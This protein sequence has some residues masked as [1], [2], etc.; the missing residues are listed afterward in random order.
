MLARSFLEHHPES[1]FSALVLDDPERD[2]GPGEPFAVVR[3]DE[4]GIDRTLFGRIAFL[5]PVDRLALGVLPWFLDHLLAREGGELAYLAPPSWVLAPLDELVERRVATPFVAAPLGP[6]DAT[7]RSDAAQE[8]VVRVLGVFDPGFLIASAS[9]RESLDWWRAIVTSHVVPAV[10]FR[11]LERLLAVGRVD[12]VADPAAIVSL[13]GSWAAWLEPLGSGFTLHGRP[14]RA[15]RFLRP[16]FGPD[17]VSPESLREYAGR[18]NGSAGLAALCDAYARR[19]EEEGYEAASRLDDPFGTLPAGVRID[20]RMR[21]LY[22]YALYEAQAGADPPPEPFDSD[23][24]EAFLEWLNQATGE[25]G[26]SRYLGRLLA[27]RRDLRD[28]FPRIPGEDSARFL[29]LVRSGRLGERID[30]RL[31]PSNGVALDVAPAPEPRAAPP[32]RD[33]APGLNVIGPF[34]CAHG[35]GEASRQILAAIRETGIGTATALSN[36]GIS[37]QDLEFPVDGLASCRYDTNLLC[38]NVNE[39]VAF[40]GASPPELFEGRYTI[41]FWW[42]EVSTLPSDLL[43]AFELVDEVW[44]GSEF[45]RDALAA[46]TEKPVVV[47]PFAPQFPVVAPRP[48]EE[49]GLPEGFLFLFAFDVLSSLERKN[50]LAIVRAYREAFGPDD[51]AALLIKSVNGDRALTALEQLRYEARGRPDI[52]IVDGYMPASVKDEWIASCDCYVSLHR[53]EGFGLT[54]AEAMAFGKPVIAT[55]YSGNMTFMREDNSYLVPFELTTVPGEDALYPAGAVWADPDVGHAAM[56]MR[57][58]FERRAEAEAVGARAADH[59]RSVLSV[60]RSSAAIER[61]LQAIRE[62]RGGTA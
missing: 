15:F 22:W 17:W 55:A 19:L 50:P 4:I 7:E 2:V 11:P 46:Y 26:L 13:V 44:V 34:D 62:G 40:A 21:W 23:R 20:D 28:A 10:A 18:L 48:R 47:I 24:P 14:V 33:L 56:L 57:R 36:V 58:V 60:A 42:W 12:I 49:L 27:E 30:P 32:T 61:R 6:R 3:P 39:I 25:G 1:A 35:L 38:V 16:R 54:I 52:A 9:A 45:V 59:V 37:R 43:P 53:S 5:Q 29:D 31:V 41:G 8:E 51:G